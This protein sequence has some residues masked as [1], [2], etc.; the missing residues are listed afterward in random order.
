MRHKLDFVLPILFFFVYF[1]WST[2]LPMDKAPDEWMR[3]LI[4]LYI[5]DNGT[6]PLG[7]DPAIMSQNWGT[8]YGFQ[9]YGASLIGFFFMKVTS[10]FTTDEAALLIATRQVS[11]IS[12]AITVFLSIR[13]GHELFSSKFSPYLLG[14]FVGLLPQFVFLAS[15]LNNEAFM[16]MCI[17][18]IAYAWVLGIENGW[19]T[20]VCVLLGVGLGLCAESY[21]FAYGYIL[22]SILVYFVSAVHQMRHGYAVGVRRNFTGEGTVSPDVPAQIRKARNVRKSHGA[23]WAG[24]LL[25]LVVAVAVG[26]WFFVRNG[27]L[28]H[29]DIFGM[30]TSDQ[31]AEIYAA[32][33]FKPSN[34]LSP[35][36]YGVSP[37]QMMFGDP[38]AW[39]DKGA[40]W[41]STTVKSFFAVFGYLNVKMGAWFYRTYLV[42]YGVGLVLLPL[43]FFR[44]KTSTG[45]KTFAFALLACFVLGVA[46]AVYYS[47]ASDYQAQGRYLMSTLIPL[48]IGVCGGYDALADKLAGLGKKPEQ[49]PVG[50]HSVPSQQGVRIMHDGLAVRMLGMPA[51]AWSWADILLVLVAVAV[52]ALFVWT[53]QDAILPKC[54]GGVL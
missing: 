19:S 6:L 40:T 46:L 21:Y 37:I 9:P 48:L 7:D 41:F 22:V 52:V 25:I 15:Y 11:T 45:E 1:A 17:A 12:A 47:W 36:D 28:Y 13:I 49:E 4:P 18:L 14:I 54:I 42:L 20:K 26:G 16:L 31:T 5:F 51:R 8:S 23:I 30:A 27:L 34:H 39:N 35:D 43:R 10:F 24:A 50:A 33:D 53:L 2:V 44:K 29:G 3:Y 32:P 38:S